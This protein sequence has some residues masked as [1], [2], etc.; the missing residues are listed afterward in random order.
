VSLPPCSARAWPRE[1]VHAA[2]RYK[3][4]AAQVGVLAVELDRGVEAADGLQRGAAHREVAAIK[5]AFV[6][7]ITRC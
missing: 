5:S 6:G 7:L 4:I 3:V 2:P 1:T